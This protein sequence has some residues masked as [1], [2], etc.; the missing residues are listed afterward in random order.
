MADD[1]TASKPSPTPAHAKPDT[2]DKPAAAP[3][4]A[5]LDT[6][7]N[8]GKSTGGTTVDQQAEYEDRKVNPRLDNRVGDQAPSAAD[9]RPKP[10]HVDGP[11]VGHF[12]EHAEANADSANDAT[13]S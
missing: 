1:T 10:Q 4:G 5:D 3:K 13:K 11:E 12:A 7:R 6:A 2:D 8:T 9:Y